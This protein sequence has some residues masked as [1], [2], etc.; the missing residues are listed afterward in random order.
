MRNV[1]LLLHLAAAILWMGGM[2]FLLMALRPAAHRQ[3]QPPVRLPLMT[4]VL[5]RFFVIVGIS[6]AVLLGTGGWLYVQLPVRPPGWQAMAVL[7]V[8]M[9]LVFGHL[10]AVPWRRLRA[11]V[12][13]GDWPEGGRQIGR[14]AT[15]AQVNFALGW[16]AIGALR[17]AV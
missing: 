13:R 8:A 4:E 5:G 16:L 10:L 9:M 11:A 14:I 12:A 17:L 6:I 3:L 1:V 15:L 2:A 7:G